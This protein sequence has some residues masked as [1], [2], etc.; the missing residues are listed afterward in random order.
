MDSTSS[1]D[2]PIEGASAVRDED[3][4]DVEAVRA[5]LATQGTELVGDIAVQQFGGGASNLTYSLRTADHDLILR[6]PPVGKKAAGAHD[7]G[8]EFRI[9]DG[10]KEAFGLVPD[11]VALCTDESVL[12]W[13]FYVMQRVDGIIPRR[14]FPPEVTLTEA[15]TRRLCLNA[16]DVL[17]DLHRVDV[18][19]T[20]LA[21]MNKGNGYVERQIT[22]WW[23]QWGLVATRELP[24]VQRLYE[25]LAAAPPRSGGTGASIVHGDYRIDNTLIALEQ[26]PRITAVVDWELSTIGDPITDVA[27]MCVYQSR[28]L[29]HVIGEAGQQAASTSDRWPD[30]TAT[31]QEYAWRS[32][33]DL[34]DFDQYLAFAYFKLAIIAEGIA[35]GP[36]QR[37]TA[38]A[39]ALAVAGQ[40]QGLQ[41]AA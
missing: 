31:G 29:D 32:G 21:S 22:R 14:D 18:N 40:I 26:T 17:I 13:D 24:D 12:G 10:L 6:R 39:G 11:M 3:A 20:P 19:A 4:F 2:E 34:G 5:W 37:Q 9:Q 16:L 1:T 36:D 33:R 7:M 38:L 35:L 28:E 27:M 8:R 15:E 25:K 41:A 30:V 23:S